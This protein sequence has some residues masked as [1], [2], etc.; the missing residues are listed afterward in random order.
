MLF[1]WMGILFIMFH[2]L[3]HGEVFGLHPEGKSST[4]LLF[5]S[6]PDD[7]VN[8]LFI[9]AGIGEKIQKA[10]MAAI[11]LNQQV[12]IRIF[13][14]AQKIIDRNEWVI[15]GDDNRDGHGKFFECAIQQR[16][17]FEIAPVIREFWVPGHDGFRQ[18]QA[19]P[20]IQHT[21]KIVLL[22]KQGLLFPEGFLPLFQEVQ[23][24]KGQALVNTDRGFVGIERRTD[25]KN[26]L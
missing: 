6:L 15:L 13:F 12:Q 5:D 3:V 21:V 10:A 11:A 14:Q 17:V 23:T 26:M 18:R 24:V 8:Q 4:I 16:I 2:T 7:P 25:G 22:G 9:P 20:V 19:G 1:L